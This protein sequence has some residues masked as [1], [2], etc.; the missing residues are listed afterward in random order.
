MKSILNRYVPGVLTFSIL[1]LLAAS[2]L[3]NWYPPFSLFMSLILFFFLI[4]LNLSYIFFKE[5]SLFFRLSWSYIISL[6]LIPLVTYLISIFNVRFWNIILLLLIIFSSIFFI[7]HRVSQVSDL[8]FKPRFN[9]WHFLFLS[10]IILVILSITYTYDFS[11]FRKGNEGL[12]IKNI[13][14]MDNAFRFSQ[15]NRLLETTSNSSNPFASGTKI[16]IGSGWVA[17]IAANCKAANLPLEDAL[18][19]ASAMFKIGFVVCIFVCT[20]FIT[21]N[22]GIAMIFSFLY[23][24]TYTPFYGEL[25]ALHPGL[26]S[27]F[28]KFTP[29][30]GG[31]WALLPV[32]LLTQLFGCEQIITLAQMIVSFYFFKLLYQTHRVRY[33]FMIGLLMNGLLL[34][35]HATF[36]GMLCLYAGVFI[37]EFV[38]SKQYLMNLRKSLV[39]RDIGKSFL[40]FILFGLPI[41]FQLL[42]MMR[43]QHLGYL[44]IF[45]MNILLL[46]GVGNVLL[47]EN[48]IAI[49]WVPA[50][51][52]LLRIKSF[53]MRRKTDLLIRLCFIWIISLL[54]S[55]FL[56][57]DIYDQYISK[58]ALFTFIPV[59]LL[60]SIAVAEEFN[61]YKSRGMVKNF[62]CRSAILF[63]LFSSVY[64][65]MGLLKDRLVAMKDGLISKNQNLHGFIEKDYHLFAKTEKEAIDWIKKNTSKN[66]VFVILPQYQ[67]DSKRGY[68]PYAFQHSLPTFSGRSV[69]IASLINWYAPSLE[70]PQ[71]EERIQ[72]S[73]RIFDSSDQ[74]E[75]IR[76]IRKYNVSYVYAG[77][78]EH[79]EF[80]A[81]E[82]FRS[83]PFLTKAFDNQSIQIYRIKDVKRE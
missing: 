72:D 51:I 8:N 28:Q 22:S 24:F 61:R 11:A 45:P 74:E 29:K 42:D 35:H 65:S 83:F 60:A 71:I 9:F 37:S 44:R 23:L 5:L 75:V 17:A 81:L 66:N 34:T 67:Y 39:L 41:L 32:N 27:F 63:L 73:L 79:K 14:G 77:L 59:T 48:Y 80:G 3:L 56:I 25:S 54:I 30:Y 13:H 18:P 55:P 12:W 49:L 6:T 70:I 15:I 76:L 36:V 31:I 69:V 2:H 78:D 20:Y 33:A 10:G 64:F 38:R 58:T 82:K 16:I 21:E 46:A 40:F 57:R 7:K 47:I 26:N 68:L 52:F 4:G 62:F 50:L 1:S 43:A 19:F 53:W